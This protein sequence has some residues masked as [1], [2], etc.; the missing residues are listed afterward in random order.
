MNFLWLCNVGPSRL[1]QMAVLV[2]LFDRFLNGRLHTIQIEWREKI[3]IRHGF[4][5]I[6]I[7]AD[8]NKLFNVRVPWSDVFISDWPL[9]SIIKSFRSCKFKRAPSLASSSPR[10]RLATYLVAAN[11]IEGL[12]LNIRVIFVFDKEM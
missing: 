2:I 7:S 6:G 5:A 4:D 1:H 9:N 12:F 10:E 8:A 3:S 11:P